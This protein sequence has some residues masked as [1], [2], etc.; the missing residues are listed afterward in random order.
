M[1]RKLVQVAIFLLVA[2]A[3]YR[4][5]PVTV[6]YV[7][8]KDA[9]Q[10]LVLFATPKTTDAELVDRAMALAD[11]HSI[12]LERDDVQVR[13]VNGQLTIDASY[14]ETMK[15]LPGYDYVRQFDV[16]AKAFNPAALR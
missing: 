8:F 11:E 4:I 6:H 12:P 3:V 15:V 7:Q 5:A 13:R 16:E 9:L 2:N 14:V 1:F 10:E